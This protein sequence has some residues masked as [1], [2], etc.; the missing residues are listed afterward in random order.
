MTSGRRPPVHTARRSRPRSVATIG[1]TTK[2]PLLTASRTAYS[3]S[4][5]GPAPEIAL[6]RTAALLV[7][8]CAGG[9]SCRSAASAGPGVS[10]RD[11]DDDVIATDHARLHAVGDRARLDETQVDPPFGD[12]L[13]DVLGVVHDQLDA[14]VGVTAAEARKPLGYEVL[15][16]GHARGD[17]DLVGLAGA[18]RLGGQSEPV[19]RLE[20]LT[21]PVD[22]QGAV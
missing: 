1:T 19:G 7:R 8:F 18:Q 14:H 3:L 10:G 2:A 21:D 15:G 9:A 20:D 12:G 5:A 13:Q 16:D 22:D 17:G 6:I 4:T 11:D